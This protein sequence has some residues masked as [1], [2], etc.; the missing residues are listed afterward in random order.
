MTLHI[1]VT[2]AQLPVTMRMAEDAGHEI[3]A[4]ARRGELGSWEW[5]EQKRGFVNASPTAAS[6]LS[7]LAPYFKTKCTVRVEILNAFAAVLFGAMSVN[8]SSDGHGW[9]FAVQHHVFWTTVLDLLR[10]PP[11]G[12]RIEI[13]SP[14][15]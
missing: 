12:G 1:L 10:S 15:S 6:Y 2:V 3:C 14:A 7:S 4:M 11:Y 9:T 8:M 13:V 5:P